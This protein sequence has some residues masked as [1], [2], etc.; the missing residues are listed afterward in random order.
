MP[1]EIMLRMAQ[2][3]T[4]EAARV[5]G[6]KIAQEMLEAVRPYVDGI[7]VTAPFGRYDVAAEVIASVLPQGA[8]EMQK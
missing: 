3:E 5:E 2:A 1:E 7:Q 8:V 6:V 4:P